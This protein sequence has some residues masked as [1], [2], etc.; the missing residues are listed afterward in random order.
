MTNSPKKTARRKNS[1][2]KDKSKNEAKPKR[3]KKS[4]DDFSAQIHQGVRPET[5]VKRGI[6]RHNDDTPEGRE[7]E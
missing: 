1:S 3:L 2:L 7:G 5:Y 6:A 4:R